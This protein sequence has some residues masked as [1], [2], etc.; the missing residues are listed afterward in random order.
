MEYSTSAGHCRR[1]GRANKRGTLRLSLNTRCPKKASELA[2]HLSF[3]GLALTSSPEVKDMR[4][5]E[6]R[7]SIRA[8]HQKLLDK[9]VAW[10]KENGLPS[11]KYVHE[12][13][14]RLR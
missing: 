12:L 2:R 10:A 11:E 9:Q 5:E 14:I 1:P 7:E 3:Y 13:K 4:H 6:I 8:Y